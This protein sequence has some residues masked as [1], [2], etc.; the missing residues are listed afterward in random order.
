MPKTARLNREI[1]PQAQVSIVEHKLSDF[2]ARRRRESKAHKQQS[3][4]A[5]SVGRTQRGSRFAKS[6][7]LDSIID[8]RKGR[9]WENW[10]IPNGFK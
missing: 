9:A 7:G 4:G 3:A 10:S 6:Q 8:F 5:A 1:L 2:R